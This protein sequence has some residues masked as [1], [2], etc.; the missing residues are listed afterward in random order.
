[1]AAAELGSGMIPG[2]PL[3][4]HAHL[5]LEDEPVDVLRGTVLRHERVLDFRSG[6][7]DREMHW[8]STYGR[9]VKIRTR[10]VC[11]ASSGG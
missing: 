7:L 6:T 1:M 10:R 9:E 8:R 5:M 11:D 2:S 4:A 3:P